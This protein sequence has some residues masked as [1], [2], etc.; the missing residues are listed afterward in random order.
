[1]VLIYVFICRLLRKFCY[2]LRCDIILVLILNFFVL[3]CNFFDIKV[4]VNIRF[5][6][7]CEIGFIKYEL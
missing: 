7:F 3:F 5:Y 4:L 1:M 2:E 6:I